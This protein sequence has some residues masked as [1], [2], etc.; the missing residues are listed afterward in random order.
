MQLSDY[1]IVREIGRGGMGVVYEAEQVSLGRRVAL[2]VL[3]HHIARDP[4]A[5]ERFR[6]EA[7]AAARLHHTNIVPVF[8]VGREGEIAFYA[9]QFIQ[10]QGLD[11]VIDELARLRAGDDGPAAGAAVEGTEAASV[12]AAVPR[13]REF[14]QVAQS[15]WK[16]RLG[17]QSMEAAGSFAE[18]AGPGSFRAEATWAGLESLAVDR[19]PAE[20]APPA[21]S[22]GSAVLPGGAAVSSVDS[23]GRRTPYFRS[24]AQI[25]RQTAQGL[26][27]AHARG[28]VHRDVKP[29]NLLLD[30]AGVVWIADFGLAKADD[31]G[32]TATGDI[33][34]TLRYMAPE[35]FRGEGDG[36][37]DVYALGLTLYELLTLRPAHQATD[38]LE[39]IE[40]IQNEEP[41]RPRSLD[42]RIPRDLET[43][44][45]KAIDKDPAGRYRSADA[46]A[47][48]LGRFL[49]DQP[50]EARR[51][52]VS[53]RYWRW[54]RRN[55]AIAALGGAL[56]A[57][58]VVGFVVMAMLWSRA[59]RNAT[60]ARAKERDAQTLAESET[61]ARDRAQEQ[62]RIALEKA[63]QL[64]REDYVNRVG[65]AYRE[66]QDDNVALAE[67]LLHGCAPERRGWE[68]NYVE[69]LCNADRLTVDVAGAS[70][71]ALA[72]SPDGAWLAVGAGSPTFGYPADTAPIVEI[73]ESVTGRP[74][75]TLAGAKGV[76]R[77]VAVSPDGRMLAAACSDGLT[78][79]WAVDTG[80]VL[81]SL[82]DP[83]LDSMSAA[84]S[85]DGKSIAVGYGYYS[86]TQT[87]HVKIWDVNSGEAIKAFASLHHGVNKV[88]Y[89]PDGKRLAVAGSNVVEVWDIEAARKVQDLKG[90]EKWVY[91]VAYS[92]DGKWI[93]TGGWDRTV[94]L[95][96]AATGTE[97]ATLF[98]HRGFVLSLAFG[99]DGR[100]LVSTSEDRGVRLWDVP[101]GRLLD[102]FHGHPDFVQA[103]A[104]RPDG[105]EFCTGSLDGS[106]RFWNLKTSRPV[107]VDHPGLTTRFAFRADGLRVLAKV[108]PEGPEVARGWD[109]FTGDIDDSLAGMSFARLPEDYILGG[110]GFRD[111]EARVDE[112]VTS[113]DGRLVAQLA[114]SDG[115]VVSR[116]KE[117]AK[118]SILIREAA[119]GRVV[120]NL[121]GHTADVVAM[122]FSP[123]GRRLAT[124][125]FDRS[126]KLWD[127]K[128]GQD[129]FTLRGHVAGV[130]SLG[131]SPDGNLIVSGGFDFKAFIWNA[132]PLPSTLIAEHDVRYRNKVEMLR[133]LNTATDALERAKIL[134]GDGRWDVAAEVFAAA[135]ARDPGNAQLRILHIEVL[136]NAGDATAARDFEREMLAYF[137]E[138][139]AKDP[140]DP[141]SAESLAQALFQQWK[142][143][144][145][146]RWTVLKPSESTSE[147]GARLKEL[148]DGSVLVEAP[149]ATGAHTIRW[150]PGPGPARALR[151]ET[152]V[153]EP[154]TAVG[155]HF[156]DECQVVAASA[157]SS[158]SEA[159]RGRFVRLDLPGDNAQFPRHPKDGAMK[160]I[161]LAELQVFHGDQN[162]AASKAARQSSNYDDR[163]VAERAVDGN[164]TGN[165]QGNPYAHSGGEAEPWW[166]VDL[167]GEQAIDRIVVWNR[168]EFDLVQRMTHFRIRV[169]DQSRRAVFE[170]LVEKAPNPSTEIIRRVLLSDTN[171][172]PSTPESQP[173]ILR[174]PI[175][176]S[177]ARLRVSAASSLNVLLPMDEAM[178]LTD[179]FAKLAVANALNGR[180]DRALQ[181]FDRSL[182]RSEG[183]AARSRILEFAAYF[184]EIYSKLISRNT[185]LTPE[186]SPS[187]LRPAVR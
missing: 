44:V 117:F 179:P 133:R 83:G 37:A 156:P 159:L 52:G 95:R 145:A 21:A 85:P 8:E 7:K 130:L 4:K 140:S 2:K 115:A 180:T 182:A 65:R 64:A 30:T 98:G 171:T 84:F 32:L 73:R 103:A 176:E 79:V 148:E 174:L 22:T 19:P 31:D 147:E 61:K 11:H 143:S 138:A 27:Y 69:R 20:V 175:K 75:R 58:L 34:G 120:H 167:G 45:L 169:L 166:E 40:R 187:H 36:R 60:F 139:L 94:K 12:A 13:D 92:P 126:L 106:I 5:L 122:A 87:G 142:S 113:P 173:L 108:M 178:R 114:A 33:L 6:R 35:R 70:C 66:L 160:I 9:M 56:A 135:I 82:T 149:S 125:S 54:A 155:A 128:T 131:F 25:G 111:P 59:E 154:G 15:L 46:L 49:D 153:Q 177:P 116:S 144:N 80:R 41:P 50:L 42:P 78:V 3:P 158:R 129:L 97:A 18:A 10:G 152:G 146:S 136:E 104:F 90:H 105:R 81:W 170:Q 157:A 88:A 124:A 168:V 47:E 53:E 184:D 151:I 14:G 62:E 183:D 16:G 86:H 48:D 38:R 23:S 91:A 109:P 110:P 186:S 137:D 134:A 51:V 67:D 107:V 118:S 141:K 96:D 121:T 127:M 77:D 39:L 100:T 17:A 162:V 102:A 123:D 28:I 1:R 55:P 181:C 164:T 63:E 132:A 29:S 43:I 165:D 150:H 89:H 72:Y 161:N 119:T 68:W 76:V 26:A 101:T 74:L 71:N 185:P 172:E 93:A 57:V 99:P 112:V 24:V 163:L